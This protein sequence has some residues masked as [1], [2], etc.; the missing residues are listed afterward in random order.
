MSLFERERFCALPLRVLALAFLI[1]NLSAFVA[2]G[3]EVKP[4]RVR[5]VVL[6]RTTREPIALANVVLVGSSRGASA[7]E[8]GRFVI[9]DLAPGVYHFR[10]SAVGYNSDAKSEILIHPGRSAEVEFLLEPSVI[11]AQAVTVT[12]GFFETSPDLPTSS[13]ALSYEEIRRAPGAAEDVQRMLQALPGVAGA[14]DQN[15][16]I[17]VRGGSPYEN[18]TVMDGVE[19][20]NINHFGYLGATGGPI[21]AVNPDF[22]REVTFSS[23]GFSARY[24]DRGSSVLDLE[25]REGARERFRGEAVLSM[26]GVGGNVEGPVAKG[27]GSYLL[28][29]RKSYLDLMYKT[30][31]LT[32]VPKYWDTQ[33]KGVYDVSER[34][35]LSLIGLYLNDRI[36]IEAEEPDAWSRGAE[37][38]ESFGH[39]YA[40][41]AR[42]R[43]LWR[44]GHSEIVLARNF[45]SFEDEVQEMPEQRLIYRDR[46]SHSTDQFDL[47]VTG[48]ARA[49]DEWSAGVGLRPIHFDYDWWLEPDTVIYDDFT[50][51][52]LPD[53]VLY[54][55]WQVKEAA[56]SFKYAGY[57]QY[58][59]RPTPTW[60]LVAGAR[61]DGFDYSKHY[62]IGPRL[63]ARWDFLPKWT[64]SLAYGIY[65][66][67]MPFHIYAADPD[68]ANRDLPHGRADHYVAGLT[69]LPQEATKLSTE[70]YY[71]DYRDLPVAEEDLVGDPTF[72]S[73]RYLPVG[74]KRVWG[75]EFFAQQKLAANWYGTLSY[76]YG[77]AESSEP[78]R[79][80]FPADYDFRHV[81]T[82]IFGHKTNL[83][84]RPWFRAFQ[85]HWYGWWTYVLPLNGDELTFSTRY[86]YV[87][88]RPY[89]PRV[90]TTEGPQF[91]SHWEDG[92]VNSERYPDYNRWDVRWDS[93]WFS[94]GHTLGI[95]LEVENV[96]DR[97]NVAEYFYADDGERNTAYQF[98]FFFVG[99]V[100][101]EW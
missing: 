6:D 93:K 35:R 101:F 80:S 49:Q 78:V 30:I 26:A 54:D 37:A 14:N 11:E 56:T 55:A 89:I 18:L 94:G 42:L 29:A 72:R 13:R 65:Y 73:H 45:L 43:S 41:G 67:A 88:G 2:I 3:A 98:R 1:T 27:R 7:D 85:K 86:R 82:L 24:G 83:S 12:T 31:G 95:F 33:F 74:K 87:T 47:H 28:S 22:L 75:F 48:R 77:D 66:Q 16:E 90:W 96:L 92:M 79:G 68:G 40:V 59:W 76:S 53:S 62:G 10:A 4:G 61:L 5:G 84:H 63:S 15:N 64:V 17:V 81:G 71:K 46:M 58:R 23:G 39:R 19:I 97:T 44:G 51:D 57:L 32:A 50:G 8:N 20:D 91:E 21:S 38:V 69:F 36:R 25:L 9:E 99:G 100:R 52:S 70:V 34:H 60:S